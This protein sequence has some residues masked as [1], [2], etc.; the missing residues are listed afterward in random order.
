MPRDWRGRFG[1]L[2]EREFRLLFAATT[3]TTAGDR[4]A[5]IALAFAVIEIGT[6]TDLGLVFAARQ[7]TQAL[8]VLF[9]G[10]LSDRLP[11]NRVL[12]GA[13]LVQ[14]VS[15][16]GT[17]AVVLGGAGGVWAI[18]ALQAAWGIGQ[19][20]VIPAEVGLVPQTVS[21]ARLQQANAL[22]GLS[23]NVVGVLGPAVGGLIVV[24]TS[25]GI[26]LAVDAAS[27]FV[28]AEL[29]RRIRVAGRLH[30][31]GQSAFFAEL[32]DGWREFTSRTWLWA[33]VILFG[34]GN[35]ALAGWQVL[36]PVVAEADLGGA[37]P[38]SAILVASGIGA[39]VGSVIAIR[40]RPTRPLVWCVL[41]AVPLSFQS[42]A[43]ALLA[44]VWVIAA[45]AFI[46]GAGLS[47]HLTLWFTVF[48]QQV[49]AHAQ[50]RVSAYDT[51]GS[52][53]LMPLGFVI[54]GPLVDAIGTSETLWCAVALMWVTW[55]GIL[56]LPS[57]WAIRRESPTLESAPAGG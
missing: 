10:V 25:P 1:A 45:A 56:A 55:I 44:P 21:A 2:Q 4:L 27:F 46:A 42:I 11:R 17:A 50:S 33:S 6:A 38:W 49:P 39:I 14:G 8:V 24:A 54:V 26:A 9:G 36:G 48:Q 43:L 5:G 23:R 47:V 51:L 20:V 35:L 37:G 16:V 41:A 30:A 32:R 3:I 40:I 34:L 52:F 7:G 13:A 53:V 31:G 22:Q 18:V 15:Q 29:L 28:C 57:V 12:A 19:G